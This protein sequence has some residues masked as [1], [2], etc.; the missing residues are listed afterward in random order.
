MTESKQ[1]GQR[2]TIADRINRRAEL[3]IR[4]NNVQAR[5]AVSSISR[6]L[7]R[8]SREITGRKATTDDLVRGIVEAADNFRLMAE[9]MEAPRMPIGLAY[10]GIPVMVQK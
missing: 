1:Y 6:R 3:N 5:I 7:D 4:L 9:V 8:A 10:E 2:Q